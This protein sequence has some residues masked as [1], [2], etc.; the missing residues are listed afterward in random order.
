MEWVR[1]GLVPLVGRA[2]LSRGLIL[3][4]ADERG[5]VPIL[6]VVWPEVTE[7]WTLTAVFWG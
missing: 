2:M 7:H 1:V 4:S 6:L 5:Y 3:L